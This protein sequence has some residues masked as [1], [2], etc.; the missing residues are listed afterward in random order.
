M[1]ESALG[2][3]LSEG[4][5][6]LRREDPLLFDLLESEHRRQTESLSL[7]ASSG[8]TDASVLAVTGSS[9]VNVTAATTRDV[10]TSTRSKSWRSSG[11]SR[12]SALGTSTSSPIAPASPTTA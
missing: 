2:R 12:S 4:V 7:V 8:G 9:I 10:V 3:C 5:D 6:K 1:K 11:P